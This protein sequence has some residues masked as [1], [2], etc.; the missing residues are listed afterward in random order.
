MFATNAFSFCFVLPQT[1]FCDWTDCISGV[2]LG[3]LELIERFDSSMATVGPW[4]LRASASSVKASLATSLRQGGST[5]LVLPHVLARHGI[6]TSV[7]Y[8]TTP[9][10]TP[11][12]TTTPNTVLIV[13]SFFGSA[14]ALFPYQILVRS[15]LQTQTCKEQLTFKYA[16]VFI[17]HDKLIKLRILSV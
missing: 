9:T 2:F 12:P 13:V 17:V 3:S 4:S 8:T 15:E 11:T 5:N 10:P 14:S 1:W 16:T 7:I 6:D